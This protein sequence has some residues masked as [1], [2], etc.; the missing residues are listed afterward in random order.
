[1]LQ[2]E[3]CGLNV[4]S[5]TRMFDEQLAVIC[6]CLQ[7]HGR[8]DRESAACPVGVPSLVEEIVRLW[9]LLTVA[10]AVLQV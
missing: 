3:C 2:F 1:M 5:S 8:C 4:A 10:L 6:R 7:N 9:M